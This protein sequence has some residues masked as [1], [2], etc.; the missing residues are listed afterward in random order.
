M[1]LG[2]EMSP[3]PR[4]ELGR[5]LLEATLDAPIGVLADCIEILST[6]LARRLSEELGET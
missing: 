2:A 6:V 1:T 5:I 3:D 4:T